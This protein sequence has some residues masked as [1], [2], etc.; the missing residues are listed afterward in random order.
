[1]E[2]RQQIGI[3]RALGFRRR[4]I[5]LS[6]LIEASFIALS[7]IVVGTVLGLVCSKNVI[8]DVASQAS[9]QDLHARRPVAA[10]RVD[11]RR[12]VRRGTARHVGSGAARVAHLPGRGTAV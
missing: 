12:G 4:M 7:A 11:L 1:M 10:P 6:F 5:Q 8:D 9:W 3:L 2:R